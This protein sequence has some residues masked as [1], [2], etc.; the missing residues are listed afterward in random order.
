MPESSQYTDHGSF[1]SWIFTAAAFLILLAIVVLGAQRYLEYYLEK[2]MKEI[3]GSRYVLQM[4]DLHVNLLSRDVTVSGIILRPASPS[5]DSAH[6]A[7]TRVHAIHLDNVGLLPYLRN[8]MFRIEDISIDRPSINLRG[9]V[10]R[11]DSTEKK[12]LTEL[13][14]HRLPPIQVQHFGITDASIQLRHPADSSIETAVKQLDIQLDQVTLDSST[15]ANPPFIRYRSLHISAQQLQ[16]QTP[17]N[18]YTFSLDS[19]YIS[20]SDSSLTMNSLAVTPRYPRYTFAEHHGFE[21]DRIDLEI[22]RIDI[23][24]PD[25]STIF[26]NKLQAQHVLVNGAKMEIFHDKRMPFPAKPHRPLPHQ[27]LDTLSTGIAID[28]VSILDSWITYSEHQPEASRAGTITFGDLSA[29]ITGLANQAS[30]RTSREAIELSAQTSI[31]DAA[32]LHLRATFPLDQPNR[33]TLEGTLGKMEMDELNPVLEPLA[34]ARITSGRIDSMRFAMEL[35]PDSATGSVIMA[36]NGLNIQML[37]REDIETGA[38]NELLSLLANTLK[39]KS[40]NDRLPLREGTVS[41][42]RDPQKSIFH[43]WWKSL[44]SGLRNSIGL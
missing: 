5:D 9:R 19:L 29:S 15:A 17:E 40:D 27:A 30:L 34:F 35:A 25:L 32:P 41:F 13:S 8:G 39:I 43:Y 37:D 1:K 42:E 20:S 33:H 2:Q 18:F 7:P 4:D 38:S 21:T 3:A 24:K 22:S 28:T 10:R 36:Y 12:W 31:M 26:R 44:L 6:F 14:N 23:V 11:P 16:S